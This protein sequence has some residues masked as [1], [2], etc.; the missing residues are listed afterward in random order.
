MDGASSSTLLINSFIPY[1]FGHGS[2]VVLWLQVYIHRLNMCAMLHGI[3][4]LSGNLHHTYVET[5]NATKQV[6]VLEDSP[7]IFVLAKSRATMNAIANQEGT[8]ADILSCVVN[9]G[10]FVRIQIQQTCQI[11]FWRSRPGTTV[12]PNFLLL[13][14]KIKWF[15]LS[16]VVK[17]LNI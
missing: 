17:L 14:D 15:V 2:L 10:S 9:H 1:C 7:K 16:I 4:Y 11:W 6:M 5:R 8:T 13:V 3:Y 12:K